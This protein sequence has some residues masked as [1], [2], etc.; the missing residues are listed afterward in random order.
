[1]KGIV[2][3]E[4]V[5][6]VEK[7]FGYETLDRVLTVD[8]LE[9]KGVYTAVGTYSFEE[10]LILLT[11]LSEESSLSINELL[12]SFGRYFFKVIN[13]SYKSIL[14]SYDNPIEFLS[15]LDSHIH[16][17]VRKIYPDAELPRFDTLEKGKDKLKLRYTSTRGMAYF[18]LGL[19]EKTFEHFGTNY[20]LKMHEAVPDS[21][22]DV[23]FDITIND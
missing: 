4:F 15:S 7:D 3:T 1:M 22:T 20:E 9:S 14:D 12:H 16:V 10:M 11:N 6:M 2:F 13:T 21:L 19:M 8:A 23:L 18:A 17:Q 5:E